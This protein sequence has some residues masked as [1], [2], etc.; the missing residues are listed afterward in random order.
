MIFFHLL[1][2]LTSSSMQNITYEIIFDLSCMIWRKNF[3]ILTVPLRER[4]SCK[5]YLSG[6]YRG[7]SQHKIQFMA[8]Q[9]NSK[10]IYFQLLELLK[11]LL[12]WNIT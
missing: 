5:R 2:L 4:P 12:M 1:Q 11:S 9:L 3:E 10:M 8:L 6:N 7:F